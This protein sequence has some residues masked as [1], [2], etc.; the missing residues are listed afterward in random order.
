MRSLYRSLTAGLLCAGLA[1][2]IAAPGE[3]AAQAKKDD[4]KDAKK[5]PKVDPKA[6]EKEMD[7][8]RDATLSFGTSDGLALRGYWFPAVGTNG[9]KRADAVMMFPAPGNKVND[10]WIGLAKSLSEKG[11]A[12]LLFDWRGCGMNSASERGIR[13]FEDTERFLLDQMNMQYQKS[14]VNRG[15]TYSTFSLRYRDFLFNDLM[16]ARF[17]LDKQNDA[18]KCNTNRI[19]VVSER[20]GAQMGLAFIATEFQRN[21]VYQA[22]VNVL[23]VGVQFKSAGK[24]Y[25]G[26]VG[27]SY[28]ATNG[29][30]SAIYRAALPTIGTPRLVKDAMVHLENRL[31]MVMVHGKKEVGS[32]GAGSSKSAI[33]GAG[34]GG[35]EADMK[36]RFKYM[37]EIDNSKQA[38]AVSGIDLIGTDDPF[39]AKE[40]IIKAMVDISK[41]KQ[42]FGKEPTDREASK[43][44]TVPRFSLE[45]YKP[46]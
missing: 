45:A 7:D 28:S 21:S 20:E 9:N 15:L 36:T 3:L 11:F 12:V 32:A 16:A 33:T 31:A 2:L 39:G 35:S 17:F 30:A 5:D 29:T 46:R 4:K 23:D 13:V 43:I 37:K 19:W 14:S 25:A 1:A 24:D 18:G 10:S 40:Y 34:A 27:L 38:K 8:T 6:K 44:T 42:D 41:D 26:L 22:K